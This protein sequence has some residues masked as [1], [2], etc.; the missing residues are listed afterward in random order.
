[1]NIASGIGHN[2]CVIGARLYTARRYAASM[3]AEKA[4][5]SQALM[6][7]DG[8]ARPAVRGLRASISLS[9]ARFSVNATARAPTMATVI[10]MSADQ[11]GQLVRVTHGVG[12][13]TGA[14]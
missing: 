8:T 2:Q 3:T 5:S 11:V 13:G 4:H 12:C 9:I 1:M 6:S 14:G 10:Q 7:P